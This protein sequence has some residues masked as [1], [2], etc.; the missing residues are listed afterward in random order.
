[1]KPISS[2]KYKGVVKILRKIMALLTVPIK[3]FLME[4]RPLTTVIITVKLLIK[5]TRY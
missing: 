1:M 3:L 2:R 4:L 5:K